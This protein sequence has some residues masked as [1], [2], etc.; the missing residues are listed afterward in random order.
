MKVSYLFLLN[1]ILLFSNCTSQ[2]GESNSYSLKA[3]YGFQGVVKEV[4]TYLCKVNGKVVPT[5]TSNF[6]GKYKLTFDEQG[7]GLINYRKRTNDNGKVV[8]YEMIYTGK[9]KNITYKEHTIIDG[10]QPDQA[11]YKYVWLDDLNYKI[12]KQ[13]DTA[14][15]QIVTLGDNYRIVKVQSKQGGITETNS[16]QD[17]I[18]NNRIEKTVT[19]NESKGFKS[20]DVMVMKEFDTH[21]NPTKIY[22]YNN[23]AEKNPQTIIFKQY[24]YY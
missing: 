4:T 21:N 6:F 3:E 10:K 14:V 11:D 23:L 18:K 13:N 7:N 17:F 5:D 20:V 1:L 12:V 2:H 19:F 9:G 22:F 16:Y 8:I 24:Q 15:N